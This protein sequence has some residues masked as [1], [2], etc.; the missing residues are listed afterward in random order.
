MLDK[1]PD[2]TRNGTLRWS[3]P[4]DEICFCQTVVAPTFIS[5]ETCPRKVDQACSDIRSCNLWFVDDPTPLVQRQNWNKGALDL[6][7]DRA[8]Y[9]CEYDMKPLPLYIGLIFFYPF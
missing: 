6:L 4:Y 3:I 1:R 7:L 8:D 5:L 2:P 9:C